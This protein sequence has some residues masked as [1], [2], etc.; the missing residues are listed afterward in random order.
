V[1]LDRNTNT[2]TVDIKS[3]STL[4]QRTAP[5]STA[6]RFPL[7][8]QSRHFATEFPCPLLGV[9][10]VGSLRHQKIMRQPPTGK[11]VTNESK[12]PYIVE[13]AVADDELDV[14]LSRRIM[15]FQVATQ[16]FGGVLDALHQS[17]HT[18]H[19]S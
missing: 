3:D 12:Y 5:T 4:V 11:A 2:V 17:S 16:G 1:A 15:D 6:A 13:M 10:R 18:R 9:V 19:Q 14:G 8:A 7:L